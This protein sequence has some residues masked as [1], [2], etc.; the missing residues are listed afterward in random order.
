[1]TGDSKKPIK[2]TKN[3]YFADSLMEFTEELS[4]PQIIEKVKEIHQ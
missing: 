4:L 2:I 3:G 1:M